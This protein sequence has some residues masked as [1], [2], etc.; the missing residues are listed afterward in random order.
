MFTAFQ[1]LADLCTKCLFTSASVS[2]FLK[3]PRMVGGQPSS[4]CIQLCYLREL[5]DRKRD[6]K[7]VEKAKELCFEH[8]FWSEVL[9]LKQS[10]RIRRVENFVMFLPGV[11]CFK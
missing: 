3:F 5:N 9:L 10:K 6:R 11:N 2:H 4:Y 8:I 7:D 1:E